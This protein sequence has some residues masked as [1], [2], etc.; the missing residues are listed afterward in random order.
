M[1][2]TGTWLP[3]F[4]GFYNTIFDNQM[5]Y[6]SE[7]DY[8]NEIVKPAELAKAMIDN[9]YN[10]EAGSKM[11]KEY[12]ESVSKSCVEIIQNELKKS[13]FVDK[14]EYEELVSPKEY[15]FANDS[16]NIKVTF[17]PENIAAIKDFIA[18]EHEAWE[19]YLKDRY[20]SY[21]GFISSHSNRADDE[22]W[23]LEDALSDSHNA[24]SILE[25]IC[26]MQEITE[27]E[28]FYD[29]ENNVGIDIEMLKKECLENGW[30]IPEG[31]NWYRFKA[32]LSAYSFR[33]IRAKA[34]KQIIF[35]TPKQRYIIAF[36]K[37]TATSDV[38]I[39][40]RFFGRVI[41]AKLRNGKV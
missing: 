37:E 6:D 14:I 34:F 41:F 20:T 4:T 10:S 32:L 17:T 18:K 26:I 11:D 31:L 30:F 19:E 1:I 16:V 5:I 22:E 12:Q 36:S 33:F 13:G 28:L 25:F 23:I 8:I 21:D 24:G 2:I 9:L 29:Y 15:N 39:T 35:E 7:I 38:F 40:K 3:I 27:E